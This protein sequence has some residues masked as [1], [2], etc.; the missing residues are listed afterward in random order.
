MTDI[1]DVVA[2][3]VKPVDTL[4][5]RIADSAMSAELKLELYELIDNAEWM[6]KVL[7][8][9]TDKRNWRKEYNHGGGQYC[10]KFMRSEFFFSDPTM[11]PSAL[12]DK[13][14]KA[15]LVEEQ[16]ARF[17][18]KGEAQIAARESVVIE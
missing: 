16:D 15:Q 6:A 10:W 18:A 2:P 11:E 4:R 14:A 17:N 5:T 7:R 9:Y 12:G 1:A 3:E 13:I 8:V